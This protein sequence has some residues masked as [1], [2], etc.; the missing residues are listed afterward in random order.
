[1]AEEEIIALLTEVIFADGAAIIEHAKQNHRKFV[2]YTS[3][4]AAL[5]II[6][7]KEVWLRNSSAMNDYSEIG[8]GEM[9]FRNVFHS[10][11][12][13]T[14]MSRSVLDSINPGLHDR[15]AQFFEQRAAQRR[16]FTYLISVSEHGPHEVKPGMIPDQGEEKYGRLSM[17]RA[18]GRDRVGVAM[19]FNSQALMA[20]SNVIGAY[21]N[22]VAYVEQGDFNHLYCSILLR[23]ERHAEAL[24][25]LPDGW[26]EQNLQRF[27]DNA[28]LALKH[29][30]FSE[31]R[32]WRITYSA[33]PDAEHISDE[34][35]NAESHV[36]RE[37]VCINGLPQRIYKIPLKDYPE[38]GFVGAELNSLME[39]IIIGPSQYP[40]MVAD[41]IIMALRNAGVENPEQRIAISNIP[42]R[43]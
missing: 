38:E 26:F 29:P 14:R 13:A 4:E 5:S 1:M 39:K 33:N 8:Y 42:L 28:A 43:T 19:V 10:D 7:K 17:W 18:Y 3:A 15:L 40:V 6:A 23:A 24:K 25:Q 12:D 36:K 9:L 16:H 21:T 30:G 22:P 31:E 34:I 35:F 41:A 11:S 32:E 37:F 27:I 2:H 20:P